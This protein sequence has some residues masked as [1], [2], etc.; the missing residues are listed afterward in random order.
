MSK[1]RNTKSTRKFQRTEQDVQKL[2]NECITR[3]LRIAEL[4]TERDA[5]YAAGASQVMRSDVFTAYI[6]YHARQHLRPCRFAA[7]AKRADTLRNGTR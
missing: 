2:V 7:K 4:E 5:A 3:R 1:N 6:P